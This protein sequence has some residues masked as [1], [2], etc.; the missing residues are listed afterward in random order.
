MLD[1]T[2]LFVDTAYLQGLYNASD[3]F[4]EQRRDKEWGMID[5]FSFVVMERYNLNA[6]LTVD[7]HF[8]QAGFKIL[9]F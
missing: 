8:V 3:Q 6:C 7:Y 2:R 4:H 1:L 5:C 9:P